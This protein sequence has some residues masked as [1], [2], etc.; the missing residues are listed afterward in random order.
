MHHTHLVTVLDLT[1]IHIHILWIEVRLTWHKPWPFGNFGSARRP[2]FAGRVCG[3]FAPQNCYFISLSQGRLQTRQRTCC[4]NSQLGRV[5]GSAI[6][7]EE[8]CRIW[9]RRWMIL[10]LLEADSRHVFHDHNRPLQP[11]LNFCSHSEHM[12]SMRFQAIERLLLR[13]RPAIVC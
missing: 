5:N 1:G 2:R 4:C 6:K 9:P 13:P 12:D 8:S 11:A 10:V 3:L 7:L